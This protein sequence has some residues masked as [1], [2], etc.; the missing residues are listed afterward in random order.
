MNAIPLYK[1]M[2]IDDQIK[3]E[4][5]NTILIEKQLRYDHYHQV[6]FI[7]MNILLLKI[8]YHLINSK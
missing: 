4:N 3:D 7:N 6:K 1:I 2:T 8:Y 5:Y